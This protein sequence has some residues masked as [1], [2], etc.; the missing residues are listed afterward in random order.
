[1]SLKAPRTCKE[2]IWQYCNY[3][4]DKAKY[5]SF[6]DCMTKRLSECAGI[7]T[8]PP[9]PEDSAT[10]NNQTERYLYIAGIVL[11]AGY[12]IYKR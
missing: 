6:Q 2:G 9:F 12:L 4:Y 5:T 1:M 8:K 10:N 3:G 7:E 11:L